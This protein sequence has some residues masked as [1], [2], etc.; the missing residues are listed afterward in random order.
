MHPLSLL[1]GGF[2]LTAVAA[3][4]QA[5]SPDDPTARVKANRYS[6]VTSGTK[7]YRPVGPLPWGDV[8]R[9]VAPKQ[10]PKDRQEGPTRPQD[11]Q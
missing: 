9:R 1:L 5:A 11:R 8:N 2:L 10:K 4:G 6:P 3:G 7:S